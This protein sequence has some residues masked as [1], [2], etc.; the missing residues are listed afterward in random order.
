MCGVV[1]KIY[2]NLFREN[3]EMMLKFNWQRNFL[4][5]IKVLFMLNGN[6]K[7]K[8][9]IYE[10]K[11][12]NGLNKLFCV[13]IVQRYRH[14]LRNKRIHTNWTRTNIGHSKQDCTVKLTSSKKKTTN[15]SFDYT[16]LDSRIASRIC[17]ERSR[18]SIFAAFRGI[19]TP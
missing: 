7:C 5:N 10:K 8:C 3:N 14:M 13:E 6:N 9:Y 16:T 12:L 11:R 1:Q 18:V 19:C 4:L 15:K 2:D 17:D